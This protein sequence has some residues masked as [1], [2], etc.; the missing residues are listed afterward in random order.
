LFSFFL[1]SYTIKNRI[2]VSSLGDENLII[3]S[4][5]QN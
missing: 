3:T 2:Y 1:T 4:T 5:Q